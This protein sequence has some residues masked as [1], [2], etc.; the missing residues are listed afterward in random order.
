MMHQPVADIQDRVTTPDEPGRTG[1]SPGM[2]FLSGW[3]S[4]GDPAMD[5]RTA[6]TYPA[7]YACK[8]YISQ[9]IASLGWHVYERGD[10]GRS[11]KPIEDDIAWMLGMQA[12]PEVTAFQWR[13]AML[14]D[15]LDGNAFSE[16]ELTNSG[17]PTWLWRIEP[18][19]VTVFLSES[20]HLLY[21]V[22]NPYKST[23]YLRPDQIF[24]LRGPSPDGVVGYSVIQ[25]FRRNISMAIETDR[26]GNN[27]FTRG[28]MPGGLL[29]VP[30]GLK[31]ADRDEVRDGF[32]RAYG[33]SANAGRVVVLFGGTKFT[34]ATISNEDAQF[35]AA[36][37][38]NAYDI[39]RIYGV[40]PHK[41]GLLERSTFAN[42]ESQQIA[43]VQ[44]CILPWVRRLEMEADVKLYGRTNRGRRYT[45]LNLDTLQRGDSAAQTTAVREKVNAGLMTPNEGRDYFG[46]DP[47]EGG[48]VL[49]VH[50]AMVP[51]DSILRAAAPAAPATD[52]NTDNTD[53]STTDSKHGSS[54][55]AAATGD[56]QATALN[57]AQIASMIAVVDKLAMD[58]YPPEGT[59]AV[60][61]AS[62][63]LMDRGLI[64]Q[65]VTSVAEHDPPA[66]AQPPNQGD[67][68]GRPAP[69]QSTDSQDA[70]ATQDSMAAAF[71]ALF[72]DTYTRQLKVEYHKAVR[73]D[74][75]GR[76]H[77][78]A[79]EFY[80]AA[81]EG[82]V[83]T[84]ILPAVAAL[85]AS[86]GGKTE[87]AADLAKRLAR[88]HL[89]RSKADVAAGRWESWDV[90][91]AA[92]AA[93]HVG[94]VLE[95]IK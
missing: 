86:R 37:D 62:F 81:T 44:D 91:P 85:L 54:E 57:G 61:Q 10:A 72:A 49:L 47:K 4:S 93:E 79:A 63:P 78:W 59:S 83:A 56:V 60:L 66:P 6:M 34:P 30:P 14:L 45:Q 50:S 2:F 70:S 69:S 36:R 1:L 55:G 88:D 21:E 8:R 18:D 89:E 38:A 76:L 27:Y 48:D 35:I 75:H 41:I 17:R 73:A 65:I 12:N 25:M 92:Q 64:D 32:E 13:E 51:L 26:Y 52:T 15:A 43:A 22:T 80:D 87:R 77:P 74:A 39:A 20:G 16:I 68:G 40:P 3:Q 53:T 84:A 58:Q 82:I 7:V 24:H 23:V 90:R 94:L 9:T 42:I 71:G 95:A 19:R 11:R 67:Y 31:K 33:G 5:K 29:E 46:L 28:P